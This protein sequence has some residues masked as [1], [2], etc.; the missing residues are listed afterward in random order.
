MSIY[1]FKA[2]WIYVKSLLAPVLKSTIYDYI[3]KD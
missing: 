3:S 1:S 2:V